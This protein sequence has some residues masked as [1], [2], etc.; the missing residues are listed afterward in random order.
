MKK[1]QEN[2]NY[3]RIKDES[4]NIIAN[5]ITIEGVDVE[6]SEEV[7][8]AYSQSD[9]RER[10]LSEDIAKDKILSLDQ[11]DQDAVQLNDIGLEVVE[12]AENVFL[13]QEDMRIWEKRRQLLLQ[14]LPTLH[15]DEQELIQ[16]LYFRGLSAREYARQLGVYHQV[17]LH[18]RDIV[19][20]KLRKKFM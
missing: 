10:Y 19:L 14:V 2:R 3:R 9:R 12:S 8:S 6:V 20:E 18:R 11:I 16:A 13:E 7:F 15:K 4:G 5:I 17:I 1:W